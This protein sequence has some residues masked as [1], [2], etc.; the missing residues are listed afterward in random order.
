MLERNPCMGDPQATSQPMPVTSDMCIDL[1]LVLWGR[2]L[3]AGR[4]TPLEIESLRGEEKGG[5][6]ANF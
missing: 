6:R 4:D 5:Q 1:G 3:P 2:A